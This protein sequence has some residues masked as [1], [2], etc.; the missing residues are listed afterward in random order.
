MRKAGF[1]AGVLL[2]ALSLMGCSGGGN[3]DAGTDGSMNND[4]GGGDTGHPDATPD[5]MQ[6]ASTA[7]AHCTDDTMCGAN[8]VLTC[9]QTGLASNGICTATC[10]NNA[11]QATERTECDGT[12]STCLAIG[13]EGDQGASTLCTR[14]C[15]T[16]AMNSGCQADQVC[17]GMWASHANA[18]PDAPGCLPFCHSDA[19]CPSGQ[20]CDQ[21]GS[22]QATA[23]NTALKADGLPCVPSMEPSSGPSTQ[24]QGACF[25]LIAND[26]QHGIC[27]SIIDITNPPTQDTFCPAADGATILVNGPQSGD[28]L[29]YCVFRQCNCDADCMAPFQCVQNNGIGVCTFPDPNATPPEHGTPS[30]PSDGGTSTDSGSGGDAGLLPDVGLPDGL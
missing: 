20:H 18:T 13:D 3:N 29:G 26:R 6:G 15:R 19:E 17:T 25:T 9:Q 2:A 12:G 8:M 5:V 24:C 30:C 10:A 16:G 22:C 27:A 7:G 14:T 21:L 23:V 1:A 11:S 4:T 28:N